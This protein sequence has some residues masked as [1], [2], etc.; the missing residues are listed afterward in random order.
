MARYKKLIDLEEEGGEAKNNKPNE[1]LKEQ[2]IVL[3]W[4]YTRSML[5]GAGNLPIDRI[6][7]WLKMYANPEVTI[8]QVKYLLDLKVREQL[9]KYS[10][11]L[12]RLNKGI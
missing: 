4:N 12:Y 2:E 8:E 7:S 1:I 11:G 9:I 5:N 6:H 3:L 10:A